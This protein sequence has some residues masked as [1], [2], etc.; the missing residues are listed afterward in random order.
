MTKIQFTCAF[1]TL[2]LLQACAHHAPTPIAFSASNGPKVIL[3]TIDGLRTEDFFTGADER[4]LNLKE[5]GVTEAENRALKKDFWRETPAARRK[6]LMPFIWNTVAENGQI[7]GNETLGSSM[8]VTNGFNFSYPGY[9][10]MLTGIADPKVNSNDLGPN[11]NVTVIEWLAAQ[12]LFKNKVAVFGA[13]DAFRDI[14]NRK[15]SGLRVRAG[16]EAM[17]PEDSR[18][19]HQM[20]NSMILNSTPYWAGEVGDAPMFYSA[21]EYLK[22]EKPS[23]MHIG[24]GETDEWGHFARYD[25]L[26]RSAY[27]TDRMIRDLWQTLQ[28]MPEY[29]DQTTLVI[30]TDHGRGNGLTSWH[31]HGTT[32]LGSEKVWIAFL[33]PRI[34]ALGERSHVVA[35]TQS[36]VAATLAALVGLD[37]NKDH[38]KVARPISLLDP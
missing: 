25:L 30:T 4:F 23:V 32:T 18:G 12:D 34:K 13:W 35:L 38:P 16:A 9:N 33:G 11:P 22:E 24:F 10:E 8:K 1:L 20:L 27:L 37:Y 31:D 26:L 3:V 29:R 21:L 28:S 17:L 6:A 36:Q 19:N 5:G 15:R 2:V 7:F 14:Y